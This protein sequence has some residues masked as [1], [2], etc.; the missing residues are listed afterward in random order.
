[1]H[2]FIILAS[3]C[4]NQIH[5][6]GGKCRFREPLINLNLNIENIFLHEFPRTQIG[7]EVNLNLS[8]PIV[9]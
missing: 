7:P 2:E 1:M 4:R 3:I 6:S 8:G 9:N 5:T